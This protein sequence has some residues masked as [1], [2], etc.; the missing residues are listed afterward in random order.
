MRM[1]QVKRVF[2][3]LLILVLV[4]S[5]IA[6]PMGLIPEAAAENVPTLGTRKVGDTPEE[7]QSLGEW[8]FFVENGQATIAGYLDQQVTSLQIPSRLSGYAVTGI[9]HRAF[10][11]CKNLADIQIPT[12]V[13]RIADDAFTGT[14]PTIV[15]YHGAYAL[16]YAEKEGLAGYSVEQD[17]M[18]FANGVIDLSGLPEGAYFGLNEESVS[19]S[20]ADASFLAEGQI[21]Y[22][23]AD[24]YYPTG[25]AKRVDAIA[26]SEGTLHVVLGQ[27]EWGECFERVYGTDDIYLDWDNAIIFDGFVLEDLEPATKVS[28]TTDA[29]FGVDIG[30]GKGIRLSGSMGVKTK[31]SASWDVQTKFLKLP[32]LKEASV[33]LSQSHYST[34]KLSTKLSDNQRLVKRQT[35]AEVPIASIGGF[36]NGYFTFDFVVEVSGTLEISTSVETSITFSY[37]N[38]KGSVNST[39]DLTNSQVKLEAEVKVGPEAKIYFVLG[40]AG[41]SIRFFEASIG[42]FGKA[43]ASRTTTMI[44]SGTEA[45]HVCTDAKISIDFTVSGK[46]GIIKILSYD[47][48]MYA[49]LSKTWSIPL[50]SG[51]YD[52][53]EYSP[54]CTL[55]NRLVIFKLENKE[56]GRRNV[57]VNSSVPKPDTPTK[58]GYTFAGWFVDAK[59]SELSGPDY[60]FN[61]DSMKMPY[62]GKSGTLTIYGKF[63]PIPVQSVKLNKDS[64]TIYTNNKNGIQL[65]ATITPANAADTSVVWTSSNNSVAKVNSNGKVTPVSAGTATI[66]CTS[67]FDSSKK[68]T[69]QVTV[70][71]YVDKV[72]LSATTDEIFEGETL[73]I[74]AKVSP[75]DASNK[76]L[77]WSSS[78]SSVATVSSSGKVTGITSGTAVITAVAN[79]RNQISG[80]YT[81][82]ILL[83]VTAITLDQTSAVL[84]TNNTAGLQL[85]P[86]L[87]PAAA[88]LASVSW[89]TG[90]ANV[91]TV[92]K[93]GLVK[94]VAPGTVTITCRSKSDRTVTATCTVTVKQYVESITI[95]STL[96][97]I[98]AD[99]SLQLSTTVLPNNATDKSLTWTSSNPNAATVDS[100]GK[101]TGVGGGTAVITA[102]A[103]DG[104]GVRSSFKITVAALPGTAPQVPV[105]GVTV[106]SSDMTAYT[107][108]RTAQ[109]NATVTP[110]G[111]DADMIWASSNEAA[112]TIDNSGLITLIRG[113]NTILTGRCVSD[114]HYYVNVNLRVVQSVE[115]IVIVGEKKVENVGGTTQLTAEV[116]PDIAENKAVT[117]ASE[118][119]E[120]ATVDQN[121]TVTGRTNGV[122][123]IT[124]VAQDGSNVSAYAF[125]KIGKDPIPVESITL[126]YTELSRYTNEKDGV[127]LTPTV[128][129][130]YADDLSVI[131]SS[132][133]EEV[134]VVDRNGRVT[135]STPGT[136]TITCRSV[137]TPSVTAT[138]TVTVKQYVEQIVLDGS[139][140]TFIPGETTQLQA[141]VY[142]SNAS[143][144]TVVWSS[145]DPAV[146]QV[147]QNGN[148]TAVGYG[149]AEIVCTAHDG[150]GASATYPVTVEKEL[151]L[152]VSQVNDTV[153]TQGDKKCEIA[154][155]SLS[156]ASVRRMAQAGCATLSW[157]M[158]KKSGSGD[159]ELSVFPTTLNWGGSDYQTSVALLTGSQFPTT[160]TEVYTVTCTAGEYE[161]STD[162]MLTVDG[163]EYASGV[164]LRNVAVGANTFSAR[165]NEDVTIPAEPWAVDGKPLPENMSLTQ[166][167]DQYYADH[168]VENESADGLT[169]N[170]DESGVY[171][172]TVRYSKGNLGYEVNATFNIADENGI[173]HMRVDNITLDNYFLHMVEGDTA[174]IVA[175]VEPND[176]FDKS[177]T[178]SSSNDQVATVTAE[179]HVR[180][181]SPGTALI[182]CAANDGSGKKTYCTVSVEK[183]LQLDESELAYTVYTG[184]EDHVS[185]DIINVTADSQQRLINDGRNVTWTIQRVSGSSTEL[186]LSDF[187]SDREEGI[188]ISGESI[189]LLRINGVGTDVYRL[190]CRA[191]S[192]TA[193]CTITVTVEE[194]NLPQTVEL[195]T[196]H[197]T[198]GIHEWITADL[199]YTLTP[200][201]TAL[202]E[203]TITA[204]DGGRAFWDAM[205]G[206]YSF[207]E[208]EKM[209]F[210]KAGSY[211]GYVIFSGTNYNY[212][213]P[214]YIDIT[215]EDG[216][217]P[218]VIT[219]V[220]INE[221]ELLMTTGESK[222]LGIIV[223]PANASYSGVTWSST[224]TAVA[225][226]SSSGKITAIGP[227][228]TSIVASIPESDYEGSCLVYVE[229][230]INFRF[231]ELERTVFVDGT[232]RTVLDTVM[233]TDNSSAR[234]G[235]APK[236]TLRRVSGISLTLRGEPIE[237]RNTQ[238]L[239][240][241]GCNLLL[242]SVSKEGDT[243]YELT[244][245][246]GAESKTITITVHAV[247]RERVLPASIALNQTEFTADIGELI[248]VQPVVTCYPANSKLP[249]G[250]VV[251]CEGDT[252]YYEALN[253]Q[254]NFVSQSL[255][256]FS[257]SKAGTYRAN[258]VYSYSNMRYVVPIIFRIRDA[259]GFV[260]VQG[261][262]VTLNEKSLYMLP[263]DTAKLEAVFTPSD[264][265][266]Q[267]VSWVSSNP[268]VATVSSDGT[269]TAVSNGMARITCTPADEECVPVSC[270]VTVED[271]LAV[272]HGSTSST[273]YVQGNQEET[274]GYA[275]LS[276][277]TRRRLE[278][279]GLTAVWSIDTTQVSHS[280]VFLD[281]EEDG[282]SVAIATKRLLSG[283][284]DTIT[285][286]CEAGN[287]SWSETYT[288]E[289]IDL[290]SSAPQ[291][292][293]IATPEVSAAVHE[294]VTIDFTPVIAPA[295]AS[296]PNGMRNSGII[297]IGNF[298]DALDQSVYAV[299][300]NQVTVAFTKPGQYLMARRYLISNLQ[301]VTACTV[302]VGSENT[303]RGV[304]E[305][306]ET[307]FTVYAGGQ[308]GSVSTVSISDAILYQFWGKEISWNAERISGDSLTVALK[309]NGSSADVFVA[310]V[311]KNGTDVWRISCTFDGMT[312]SIDITLT[313]DDPRGALPES[314][315]LAN[316]RFYGEIGDIIT[317]P[318]GAICSPAGSMLPDQGDGFWSFR[319]DTAGEERSDHSI[320]NGMLAVD[321]TMSGYYTGILKYASGN[322]SYS[323]PLYFVIRD[324]EQEI[325]KPDLRLYLL[326]GFDTVY[327][328]GETGSTIGQAVIAEG[329]STYSTGNAVAYMQDAS[330]TWNITANGTAAEVSLRRVSANVYDVIL[331]RMNGSGNITYRITCT[332]DGEVYST[333]HAL[334]VAAAAEPRPDATLKQTSYQTAVGERI[335]IDNRMYSR[336]N[337]SVLQSSTELDT[338]GLL[339]AVGYDVQENSGGWSMVFYQEGTYHATVSTQVSN[340]KMEKEIVINVGEKGSVPVL[341]VLQ[342]P[343]A[344]TAIEEE[345]FSGV[346]A[347][348]VDLRGTRVTS[349]GAG[350]FRNSVNLLKVY[351]PDS[352]T[353]I[354]DDAFYGCINVTVI[355]SPGSYAAAWA[356]AH[357]I[358][359]ENP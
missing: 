120:I 229:E 123:R 69:F 199:S 211:T 25:L 220:R 142:P 238:G 30:L 50:A 292:V 311:L 149:T 13:T 18:V 83:P 167:S 263:N 56:V 255:S 70:K 114:P 39:R 170:F 318:L 176:A 317:I 148:I 282:S 93:N 101:I 241:Y 296:L 274:A 79:D 217:I 223:E 300:G 151:Q 350:A 38:G 143:D 333:E 214:I 264:T 153:Y 278:A 178:W 284:T 180:A 133:D 262:K 168:A 295:G 19:F 116:S 307:E 357:Q 312:E 208:P 216:T 332:V 15:A 293:S 281:A 107:V 313:A 98:A 186:G 245:S 173:V 3:M 249:N 335:D 45:R 252:Q 185:L 59:A 182:V 131:W 8:V 301:Y 85:H 226:V 224:N 322:V 46:I 20:T 159:T 215:D 68:D 80:K 336:E 273:L 87:T 110:S 58:S 222:T 150:S 155:V 90:N 81:V 48:S 172:S 5:G 112:A 289:V 165:I 218:P 27:P 162:I 113:G 181:V 4:F 251:S 190:E 298:Y 347:N 11:D 246:S 77:T 21:L 16:V 183:Y 60:Q 320:E 232:T 119:P 254:D 272:T 308:S 310:N 276:E 233:L 86:T 171:T 137:M 51:H 156:N 108:D 12:N 144:K 125:V 104:S 195:S 206:F 210:D 354:G 97:S 63:D 157:S 23:P 326:N 205:S 250:I 95:H 299:N 118:N 329:L 84:Y 234:I 163:T 200:E 297:G 323:I 2:C 261:S 169:V 117:W 52:N 237:S 304:L 242:Y 286:S 43:N 115:N 302:T 10:S 270:P 231:D 351:I 346:S 135:F 225:T 345:A 221:E 188:A 207:A 203:G 109:V 28:S 47:V 260:P 179:G 201:G 344:L 268:S 338:T 75:S 228:Y 277:G 209:S 24:P 244:C 358:R 160:G 174:E 32:E 164:K 193:F 325:R 197:Y 91:A 71:Q 257:F 41:F 290:G 259:E 279:D 42:L 105:T 271:Y 194:A 314:I 158:E 34:V 54:S 191:D 128:L 53:M 67:K 247:N 235:T 337:G 88:S 315:T 129:P 219:D 7:L 64:E 154:Y 187:A 303:G 352:V 111:A 78:N 331:D 126:D 353:S 204:I 341:T 1:K 147:N 14:E 327:P 253:S 127:V 161:E 22:F 61:F 213:C 82:E 26:E 99:E 202:P 356:Q 40:V 35:I 306:T 359:V 340:L 37:K 248:V 288:L 89:E 145:S 316:D 355:C 349:I 175:A 96:A 94:P 134:A 280:E 65:K 166:S 100:T 267:A 55:K 285:V 305:A 230:G 240:I 275:K 283:G 324:E 348:V 309:E 256:T 192:Y 198:A 6:E 36:I 184:G 291:S 62:C 17:S 74:T 269:V 266:N 76:N 152:V 92:S 72:T 124:A 9:G 177:L 287:Y 141:S 343:T 140:A 121:G 132:S 342:M 236:W 130:E 227:G 243:V 136:A 33:T 102:S 106:V 29:S 57:T 66:T 334:H 103:N 196:D 212:R 73:Q 258:M 339:A 122:A 138:C 328:E 321:F 294:A 44:L 265:S 31:I 49:K 189:Q 239:P 139:T 319:F 330:A 146:A